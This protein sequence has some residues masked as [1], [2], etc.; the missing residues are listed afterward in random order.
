MDSMPH[1]SISPHRRDEGQSS[2]IEKRICCRVINI[3]PDLAPIPPPFILRSWPGYGKQILS[4][5]HHNRPCT[6]LLLQRIQ[7]I[8][9]ITILTCW[10]LHP[11]KTAIIAL[12]IT[13]TH[14]HT[15]IHS[16]G[17]MQRI[18]S[19]TRTTNQQHRT[20]LRLIILLRLLQTLL[21]K[22]STIFRTMQ[23]LLMA[24]P[25]LIYKKCNVSRFLLSLALYLQPSL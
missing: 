10:A 2:T 18:S 9:A 14:Q 5:Q 15:S 4:S 13:I 11:V 1:R 23:V 7:D 19:L 25:R 20:S 6:T 3:Q 21:R 8:W 16:Y 17:Q 22:T 12:T 24:T